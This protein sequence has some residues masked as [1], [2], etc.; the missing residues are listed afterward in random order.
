MACTF[1]HF[2][3]RLSSMWLSA[4]SANLFLRSSPSRIYAGVY[5]RCIYAFL[6]AV[7]F[8]FICWGQSG[9]PGHPHSRAH[10]VFA[11]PPEFQPFVAESG[12]VAAVHNQHPT[13][14]LTASPAQ[15]IAGQSTPATLAL[16]S[17]L[18]VFVPYLWLL[19]RPVCQ[20]QLSPLTLGSAQTTPAPRFPPPRS[21]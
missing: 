5:A 1:T 11:A 15:E 3:R 9:Q 18:L 17:L 4:S 16:F 2:W 7:V 20:K 6:L 14:R 13:A 19:Y 12:G 10:F 8:P 21:R